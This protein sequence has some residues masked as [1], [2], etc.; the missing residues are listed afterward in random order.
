MISTFSLDPAV[1]ESVPA[2]AYLVAQLGIENGRMIHE[3]FPDD[4]F[5]LAGTV[6]S[7]APTE[8]QPAL[9]D[10]VM[11]LR[12]SPSLRVKSGL[13]YNSVQAWVDNMLSVADRIDG[14]ILGDGTQLNSVPKN[15]SRAHEVLT[16]SSQV[17]NVA[18]SSTF[19]ATV[20]D[21]ARLLRPLI[22]ISTTIVVMDPF[23][24][25]RGK[26][27]EVAHGIIEELTSGQTIEFHAKAEPDSSRHVSSEAWER[28]CR[29]NLFQTALDRKVTIRTARWIPTGTLSKVHERWVVTEQGGVLLDRG[30]H[31]K[32]GDLGKYHLLSHAESRG[33]FSA[34]HRAT[35]QAGV[36]HGYGL[37]DAVST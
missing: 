8:Q 3:D 18:R 22:R 12:L 29:K 11:K 36:P 27:L 14:V 5:E 10:L 9:T 1:V 34:F 19:P 35:D 17:W 7:R 15:A 13:P 4:W 30:L 21:T 2:F 20:E 28:L 26:K 33:L 32:L 25:P 16:G 31:L 37:Y 6:I 23:F 24:E